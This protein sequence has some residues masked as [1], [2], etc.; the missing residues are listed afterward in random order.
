MKTCLRAAY[1]DGEIGELLD[2]RAVSDDHEFGQQ[3]D[4]G[5]VHI[6]G[7]GQFEVT[8][9]KVFEGDPPKAQLKP[10]T[11]NGVPFGEVIVHEDGHLSRR[12]ELRRRTPEEARAYD[13]PAEWKALIVESLESLEP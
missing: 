10:P 3:H 5:T 12:F 8:R 1:R 2:V 7:H 9:G 4:D 11:I 6:E 13:M